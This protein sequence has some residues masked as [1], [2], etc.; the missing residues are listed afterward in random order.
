[1]AKDGGG[2]IG[3]LLGQGD[4]AK[5]LLAETRRAIFRLIAGGIGLPYYEKIREN[6]DTIEGRSRI[7]ALVAEE[8]GRQAIADPEF[9]ERAKLVSS[10]TYPKSRPTSKQWHA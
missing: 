1:M 4:V 6:L 8:V 7:N 2:D 10:A 9:M 3:K 5:T